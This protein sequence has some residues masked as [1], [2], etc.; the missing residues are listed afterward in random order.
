MRTAL[1][2]VIGTAALVPVGCAGDPGTP[3][4]RST[5][6]VIAPG[7]PGE[8]ARTLDPAEAATVVPSPTA[9]AA[10][11]VF[12]QDMIVH[13]RQALDMSAAAP[14]RA[15]SDDVKRMASRIANTQGPEINAMIRWL[16]RQGQ[17]VPGHHT[18]HHDMPGM[19]T[20]EQLEQLKAAKGAGF[21][22]LYLRLMVAHH[23]GAISMAAGELEKGSHVVAE[24]LAQDI[25]VSQ[26]AEVDRMR[27]LDAA[28]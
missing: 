26:T 14:A 27:R 22:H 28:L 10:D 19:A 8:A 17:R 23:I 2:I 21:D 5:A 3:S 25:S 24:E 11:V 18:E 12:M 20:P 7:R 9:G 1:I 16:R 13:H 4:A 6:P 15:A